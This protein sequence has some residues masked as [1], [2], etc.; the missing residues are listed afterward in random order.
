MCLKFVFELMNVVLLAPFDSRIDREHLK[1]IFLSP[2]LLGT[3]YDHMYCRI[4]SIYTGLTK[5]GRGEILVFSLTLHVTHCIYISGYLWCDGASFDSA[6]NSFPF[7]FNLRPSVMPLVRTLSFGSRRMS[8]GIC[9]VCNR[10]VP[11]TPQRWDSWRDMCHLCAMNEA[12]EAVQRRAQLLAIT[13]EKEEQVLR[14]LT[15]HIPPCKHHIC[16]LCH[17][18]YIVSTSE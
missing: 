1:S 18:V 2:L 13:E 9:S 10:V 7:F 6:L 17:D 14:G 16:A 11:C 4:Q 15:I 8:S 3:L 5:R 12:E